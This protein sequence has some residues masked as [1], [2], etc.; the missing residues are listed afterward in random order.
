MDR[1]RKRGGK[2]RVREKIGRRKAIREERRARR[3]KM[4]AREK[5]EKL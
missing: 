3:K 2:T 4:Q 1:W 5:V